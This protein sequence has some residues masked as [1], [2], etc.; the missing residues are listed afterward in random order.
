MSQLKEIGGRLYM[1]SKVVMLPTENKAPLYL[2]DHTLY[3]SNRLNIEN[4]RFD[5]YQHLYFTSEEEIKVGDYAIGV[6]KMVY[7]LKEG[8]FPMKADRKII[9]TTDESLTEWTGMNADSPEYRPLP[10][11]SYMFLNSFI[12]DH[13]KADPIT[14][15]LIEYVFVRTPSQIFYA[16][17]VPY[18]YHKPIV[19]SKDNTIT[20]KPIKNLF[21][22]KE[23]ETLCSKAFVDGRYGYHA[24]SD[25]WIKSN[26]DL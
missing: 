15:V 24:D 10:K 4:V 2:N 6:D 14:D 26:I 9:A 19:N 17:E 18:G 20:V 25:S 21:T 3:T 16:N 22:R 7:Q 8:E 11:P 1:P 13:N 5:K 12:E 23:L